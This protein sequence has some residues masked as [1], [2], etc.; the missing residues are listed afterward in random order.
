MVNKSEPNVYRIQGLSCTNCA[1]KFEDNVKAL[2][3]VKEAQIN[4]EAAKLTVKGKATIEQLEKAGAFDGLKVIKEGE[5]FTKDT[6]PFYIKH[7][8]FVLSLVVFGIG[9][10]L[11]RFLGETHF[12]STVFYA[13]SIIIG[14]YSLFKTGIENL[15]V[16]RFDMKTLMTIAIIGAVIIGEWQEGAMVVILFAIAEMLEKFSMEKARKSIQSLVEVASKEALI[17]KDGVEQLVD[18]NKVEIGQIMLVKPGQKIAMDGVIVKGSST[19]NQSSITGESIPVYKEIGSEV[20]AGTINE[21]GVI[22]VRVTKKYKDTTIAKM[23]HLVEEANK[24]K[25]PAQQFIDRFASFY[26]PIIMFIALLVA[27]VPPLF[28]GAD[29]SVWVYQGLSVLVVGCPCALVISTPVAIV[30][31]IGTAARN[32]VLIKGGIYLEEASK[33]EA[34]LFDKTG[35]LTSG[36]PKVKDILT[37]EK[38]TKE[39]FLQIAA[40][41]EKNSLHP[42]AKAIVNEAKLQGINNDHLQMNTFKSIT[43]KGITAT[44]NDKDYFLGNLK[45]FESFS[46][47]PKLEEMIRDVVTKNESV[48]IL[49]TLDY[50][51]GLA[52]LTDEIRLTSAKVIKQLHELN[53]NELIMLTGDNEITAKAVANQLGLDHYYAEMLPEDKLNKIKQLT[54]SGKKVAMVGDGVNDAPALAQATIGVAMGAKGTDAALETATIVLMG[55]DLTKLP[56]IIRLSKRTMRIIKQNIVF[57]LGLKLLALALVIPGWLTLWIAIFADIGATLLVT[58]NSLRLLKKNN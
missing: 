31:A 7:L 49:G 37:F 27:I 18:V 50:F 42:L 24:E 33:I 11:S 47:Y 5:T 10:I 3:G 26:T 29:A 56:F 1:K 16:L 36:T 28:F 48:I 41:M 30:T 58:F 38:Y 40:R 32:G 23:I 57:S 43:G 52:T 14:G 44:I 25:A 20:F 8:S 39:E 51:I 54:S 46:Y 4:F 22:E 12:I 35:T 2:D 21:D 9:F 53:V 55:D 19:I 6:R 17:I 45:M 15:M 34:I 13:L